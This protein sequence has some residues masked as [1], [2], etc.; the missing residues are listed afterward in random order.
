MMAKKI[1]LSEKVLGKIKKENLKPKARFYF[2]WLN[3]LL[4]GGIGALTVVVSFIINLIVFRLRYQNAQYCQFFR[5][6]LNESVMS[7]IPWMA[8]GLVVV[9]IIGSWWLWKKIDGAYRLN[10]WLMMAVMVGAVI[11]IGLM[12]DGSGFNERHYERLRGVYHQI[13]CTQQCLERMRTC[14]CERE[15]RD[16]EAAISNE[17][18]PLQAGGDNN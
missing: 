6:A 16:G 5:A 10:K 2:V 11:L 14:G 15:R 17:V 7:D 13:G 8:V 3:V 9:G 12:V 4:L 1:D 18:C